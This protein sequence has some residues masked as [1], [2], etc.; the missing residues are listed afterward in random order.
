MFK[1]LILGAAA[2]VFTLGFMPT[3]FA[4]ASHNNNPDVDVDVTCRTLSVELSNFTEERDAK[5][6]EYETQYLWE[7]YGGL[8]TKWAKTKPSGN[9]YHAWSKVSP[10]QKKVVETK[11][12]VAAASN[13]VKVTI[14]GNQ[15]ANDAF[16]EDYDDS[17]TFV[18]EKISHSYIVEV[19]AWDGDGTQ[20][21]S[22]N[23]TPCGEEEKVSICH[24]SNSATNPYQYIT[25]NKS[26]VDGI[27]G[28]SG[29]SADHYGEHQGPIASSEAVANQ[30]KDDKIEW[31]DIIPPVA[32]AHNGYNYTVIGQAM[33][34]NGCNFAKVADAS[35]STTQPTCQTAATLAYGS[36][37]NASFTSG[38]PNGTT[39]PGSYSVTVTANADSLFNNTTNTL[40][41]SGTLADKLS[42][43][44]C[45]TPVVPAEV[46]FVDPTCETDGYFTIPTT[47]GVDYQI[48][49]I[50]Q[51]AGEYPAYDGDSVI[52]TA[53]AQ[54]GY[55]LSGTTVWP[56]EFSIDADCRTRVEVEPIIFVDPTC[57]L[58][59]SYTIPQT[60]GV[61][62]TIDGLIVE[63][64][65]YEAF[66]GD[67]VTIVPVAQKDYV[68][69]GEPE[70][71]TWEFVLE[72]GCTDLKYGVE[73]TSEGAVVT[74]TNSGDADGEVI[75]NGEVIVVAAGAT[76]T[77]TLDTTD[78]GLQITITINGEIVYDKLVT[79]D[80]GE[81]L[82]ET[83]TP[84]AVLP[85]TAATNPLSLIAAFVSAASALGLVSVVARKALTR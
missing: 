76:V 4:S 85:N 30:L 35:V 51:E 13:Y 69:V 81:V 46:V 80:T 50:T 11:A 63:A 39:G 53:I 43:E 41:L 2:F 20:T 68:L 25:V 6:A 7:R 31:G 54:E 65:T 71:S 32:G 47:I 26:S 23:S 56:Y 72:G 38:T 57:G 83:T 77:R 12:A 15:V 58:A 37:T 27:S 62:Y 9:G 75:L 33:L 73:C 24:R 45:L 10:E 34:A 66:D 22:G 5:D 17:W 8:E 49:G 40:V 79:C 3:V 19:T 70:S 64:G 21:K 18:N 59:G 44:Q 16:G 74:L 52:V 60:T 67:S 29:Q 78:D 1:K 28:N 84:P 36:T 82:G 61:D 55:I 48:D 42:G 14:D